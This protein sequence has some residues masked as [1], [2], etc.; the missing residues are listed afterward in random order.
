MASCRVR[1]S[2]GSAPCARI[3]LLC[4]HFTAGLDGF[5]QFCRLERLVQGAGRAQFGCHAEKI[6]CVAL[7]RLA[8]PED[9][10]DVVSF[11]ASNDSRWVTGRTLL[12]D[13]GRM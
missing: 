4:A 5:H 2:A 12:T 6:R 13:G 7:G 3:E 10:A 11:L 1:L 8:E 9:I